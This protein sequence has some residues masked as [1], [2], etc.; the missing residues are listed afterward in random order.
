MTPVAPAVVRIFKRELGNDAR[1][2]DNDRYVMIPDHFIY[3]TGIAAN[4]NL[5]IMRAFAAEQN[6]RH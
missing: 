3:T 4:R 5:D 2:G 6:I 1:V